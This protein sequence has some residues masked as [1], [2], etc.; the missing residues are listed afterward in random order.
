MAGR[1]HKLPGET[2]DFFI[3]GCDGPVGVFHAPNYPTAPG[4]FQ[5][6]PYRGPGHAAFCQMLHSGRPA[7]CWLTVLGRRIEFE[8]TREDFVLGPPGCFSDWFVEVSRAGETAS[9]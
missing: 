8:V 1:R 2:V 5:Y 3:R 4:R 9:A 7:P 6:E